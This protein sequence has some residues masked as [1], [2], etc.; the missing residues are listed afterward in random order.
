MRILIANSFP[1]PGDYDGTAMLPIKILRALKTRG[2]DVVVAHLRARPPWGIKLTREEFE[3][4]PVYSVPPVAW[5]SGVGLKQIAREHPFELVHAQH[6]GGATRA[7]FACRRYHWPMVY[8]IHSLPA[9]EVEREGLGRRLL[10]GVFCTRQ[11]EKSSAMS[12]R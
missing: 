12:P 9:Q 11:S 3:G 8:E 5:V 6:H 4:T 1:I 10:F 7:S 2:V